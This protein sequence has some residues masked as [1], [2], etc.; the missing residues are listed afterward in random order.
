MEA[1]VPP[2][3]PNMCKTHPNRQILYTCFDLSCQKFPSCCILC[4]KNDHASCNDT[5]LVENSEI[6]ERVELKNVSGSEMITFRENMKNVL[7]EMHAY[8]SQKYKKFSADSLTNLASETLTLKQITNGDTLKGLKEHCNVV[9]DDKGKIVI[10]QKINPN[11][12]TINE[13]IRRYKEEIRTLIDEFN[14]K[15]GDVYFNTGNTMNLSDFEWHAKLGI[16]L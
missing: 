4:V 2:S 15:L 7:Q 14:K 12:P 11:S 13:D 1:E 10:S 3:N 6:S 5:L 16:F 9:P 8:M